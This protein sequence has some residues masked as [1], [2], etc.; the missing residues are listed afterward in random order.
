[1]PERDVVADIP[2]SDTGIT[3]TATPDPDSF[4]RRRNSATVV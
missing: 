1:M 3:S 2:E 4:D